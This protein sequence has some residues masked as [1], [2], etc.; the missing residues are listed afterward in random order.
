VEGSSHR[1]LSLREG[2]RNG[3]FSQARIQP[4]PRTSTAT[5][6]KENKQMKHHLEIY[7]TAHGVLRKTLEI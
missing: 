3:K 7:R 1:E 5:L 2:V 4:L 6:P